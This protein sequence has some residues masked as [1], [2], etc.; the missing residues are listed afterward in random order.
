LLNL[1]LQFRKMR[2]RKRLAA[3][4]YYECEEFVPILAWQIARSGCGWAAFPW[5]LVTSV[6]RGQ[7]D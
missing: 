4:N 5:R 3:H 6:T 7:A 2:G 1:A